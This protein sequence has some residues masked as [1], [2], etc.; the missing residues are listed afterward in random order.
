M[1]NL[2]EI[3][4]RIQEL[5]AAIVFVVTGGG[6]TTILAK[7]RGWITFGKP[8]ERRKC[9]AAVQQVCKEHVGM[10]D[11]VSELK[12]GQAE[13]KEILHDLDSKVDKLIGYHLGKNGVNLG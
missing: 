9:P 13:V 5:I 4:F 10:S 11:D 1:E 6:L 2:P 7:Q 3:T 12:S 8:V